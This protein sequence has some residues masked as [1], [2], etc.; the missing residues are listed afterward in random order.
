MFGVVLSLVVL[1]S[2]REVLTEQ[3]LPRALEILL[4]LLIPALFWYVRSLIV[5]KVQNERTRA[6]LLR[7][8]E[9]AARAVKVV[10]QTF[11]EAIARAREDGKVSDQE[12]SAAAGE[13]KRR[14]IAAVEQELGA[15]F[16]KEAAGVLA[17]PDG[18]A[19]MERVVV[20]MVEAAVHDRKLRV[21][22]VIAG[23]ADT[24]RGIVEDALQGAKPHPNAAFPAR[25]RIHPGGFRNDPH[26]KR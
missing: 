10:Q 7:L 1:A 9:A 13:A 8:E 5:A 6:A 16:L 21:A 15:A 14:A 4:P 2:M 24:A 19:V 17:L 20:P 3:V 12:W 22:E 11:V 25:P 23:A 26:A 18:A